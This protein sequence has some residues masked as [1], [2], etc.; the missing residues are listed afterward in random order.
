M[1]TILRGLVLATQY[2][3]AQKLIVLH[4]VL[5]KVQLTNRADIDPLLDYAWGCCVVCGH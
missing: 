1:E 3:D 4:Q 5:D 2:S